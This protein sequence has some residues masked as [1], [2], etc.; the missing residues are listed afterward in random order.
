MAMLAAKFAGRARKTAP[1]E[2]DKAA[3]RKVHWVR[4]DLVAEIAFA[5]YTAGGS[6]RHASFVGLRADK[7]AKDVKPETKAKAP[8]PVSDVEISSRERVIF[9]EAKA[10]KGDLADYYAAVAPVMLPHLAR[11]PVSLVRCPQGRAKQCFFQKHD[12]GSFGPHVHHVPIEEKDGGVED[13]L[14]VE[15]ADGILACVQMG[16]IEFHGWG[17]HVDAVER[18]DRMVFDLDPDE[19]LDFADVK[20]PRRT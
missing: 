1:V 2:V 6:V 4:P 18:P 9:P 16:T 13:Y 11:R 17:S 10:T 12:S 14:Y 15:D 3:A 19:G 8:A 7:E 20:R 5:E